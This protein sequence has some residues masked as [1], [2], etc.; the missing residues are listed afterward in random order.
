MKIRRVINGKN[1]DTDTASK[2]AT[3]KHCGNG[4]DDFNFESTGLYLTKKGAWFIAGEGGAMTRWRQE[5]NGGLAAGQGLEL[6]TPTEAQ[7]FLEDV[8]GPVEEYFQI[9]EG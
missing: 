8:D 4:Y 3:I 1:Y 6:A 9:E 5:V 2:V 7:K